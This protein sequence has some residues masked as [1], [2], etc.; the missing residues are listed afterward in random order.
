MSVSIDCEELQSCR[1]GKE[2]TNPLVFCPG[3]GSWVSTWGV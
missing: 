3:Q 1:S 2:Y